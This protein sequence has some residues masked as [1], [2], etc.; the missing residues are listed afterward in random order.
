MKP[1]GTRPPK[2]GY[3]GEVREDVSVAEAAPRFA[4]SGKPLRVVDNGGRP[5]GRL[6]HADVVKLMMQ[7]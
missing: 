7:G 1:A 4:G 3:G 6:E 2:G 5:V